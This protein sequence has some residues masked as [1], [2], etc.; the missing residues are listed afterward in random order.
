MP[1]TQT[2][3]PKTEEV[4]TL[5]PEEAADEGLKGRIA[6]ARIDGTPLDG[7]NGAITLGLQPVNA[8]IA[9]IPA[10]ASASALRLKD[11]V[12]ESVESQEGSSEAVNAGPT[13]REIY[14]VS[15]SGINPLSDEAAK[16]GEALAEA[17]QREAEAK[18]DAAK[19]ESEAADA[20]LE[21]A[22]GPT[23]QPKSSKSSSSKS[24]S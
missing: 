21:A 19:A 2:S 17:K 3:A 6:R 8:M 11:D 12:I 9:A 7:A 16:A 1:D 5:T 23:A 13:N 15:S 20:A 18:A 24:S 4:K 22:G 14:S 10:A